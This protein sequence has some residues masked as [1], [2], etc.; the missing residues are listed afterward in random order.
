MT[1]QGAGNPRDTGSVQAIVGNVAALEEGELGSVSKLPQGSVTEL[2]AL[3][4]SILAAREELKKTTAQKTAPV[5]PAG[6]RGCVRVGGA[7]R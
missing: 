3:K 7:M 6:M 2:D 1:S 5:D 4:A